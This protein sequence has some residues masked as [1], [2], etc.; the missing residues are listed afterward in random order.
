MTAS[1]S[2]VAPMRLHAVTSPAPPDFVLRLRRWLLDAACLG[3]APSV[4][5]SSPTTSSTAAAAKRICSSC[6]V[7]LECLADA[8]RLESGNGTM[9]AGMF[10]GLTA[11][12]RARL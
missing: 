4:F 2:T 3:V 9:R 10:G 11:S 6:S 7:W 12:E 5:F 8:L 1:A